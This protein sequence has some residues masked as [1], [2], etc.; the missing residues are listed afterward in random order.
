LPLDPHKAVVEPLRK[1]GEIPFYKHPLQEDWTDAA[2]DP[3]GIPSTQIAFNIEMLAA[4]V[5]RS[6][7]STSSTSS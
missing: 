5:C 6:L 4:L 1:P 3:V 7:S 2:V